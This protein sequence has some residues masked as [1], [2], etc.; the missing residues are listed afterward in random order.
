MNRMQ[1]F[2]NKGD[3]H[4]ITCILPQ[5]S[6]LCL[7]L[8]PYKEQLAGVLT[9]PAGGS[10]PAY[11]FSKERLNISRDPKDKTLNHSWNSTNIE[12]CSLK[13]KRSETLR[14]LRATSIRGTNCPPDATVVSDGVHQNTTE[15]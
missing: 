9:R 7:A 6:S 10:Y 3:I 12:H 11:C 14:A 5:G 4:E 1:H 13:A 2:S 15:M 8:R